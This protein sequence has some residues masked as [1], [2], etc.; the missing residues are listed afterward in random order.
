MD[1]K[2]ILCKC[3]KCGDQ[4]AIGDALEQQAIEQVRAEL[5]SLNDD[6]TQNL[7][8]AEK[9]KAA[10]EAKKTAQ[11]EILKQTRQKQE[12]LEIAQTKLNSL[13]LERVT[14]DAKLKNFQQRQEAEITIKLAEEKSKWDAEKL[15]TET[16]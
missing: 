16:T 4:F 3:P 13:E 11:E 12:E 8:E 9:T 10:E 14:T 7:I 15:N 5:A 6:E 1:L 2:E